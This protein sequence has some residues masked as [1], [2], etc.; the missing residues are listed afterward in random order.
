MYKLLLV[1]GD[2][3]SLLLLVSTTEVDL[4]HQNTSAQ[5]RRLLWPF[6]YHNQLS[7]H[8]EEEERSAV[9]ALALY[10]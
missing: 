4:S 5:I 7:H 10:I 9:Q 6:Y 8:A 3:T 1:D 2:S